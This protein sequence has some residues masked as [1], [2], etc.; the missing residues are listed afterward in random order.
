MKFPPP[1][2]AALA[3]LCFLF[4][5][6]AQGAKPPEEPPPRSVGR[7]IEVNVVRG[8]QCE[9]V[10]RGI[11]MPKNSV[12]FQV[13]KPPIHGTLGSPRRIDKDTV[14]Y[15]YK[16]NGLA[17]ADRDR[18]DFKIKTG[19]D[20]AWGRVAAKIWI[21]EP[22][23]RFIAEPEALDFGPVPIGESK[24]LDLRIRN[25]GGGLLKGSAEISPP[26]SIRGDSD[27]EL[28]EGRQIDLKVVFSPKSPDAQ[29]G[30]MNFKISSGARTAVTLRGMGEYRFEIPERVAFPA[31]AGA[32]PITVPVR[33]RSA[34]PLTLHITAEPPLRPTVRL[35]LPPGGSRSFSLELEKG[36]YSGKLGHVVVSDGLADQ[37]VRVELPPSPALLEWEQGPVMDLGKIPFRHTSELEAGLKNIGAT[38]TAVTLSDGFGGLSL[39]PSQARSF[40]LRSGETALVKLVWKLPEQPGV[41]EAKLTAQEGGVSHELG[42]KILVESPV[43]QPPFVTSVQN[44]TKPTPS[45]TP[46]DSRKILSDSER[47]EL[48]RRMPQDVSY[49]LELGSGSATAVVN[50]KYSG[51]QPVLFVLERQVTERGATGFEKVFEKR[52]EVPEQLPAIPLIQKWVP[53]DSSIAGIALGEDGR[54]QGRVP[55][56]TAGFHQLRIAAKSPPEGKRTDYVDFTV[57]VGRL[58]WPGWVR[59]A[60]A[61]LG[62]LSL[63]YLLRRKIAGWFGSPV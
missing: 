18:G 31:R 4:C 5:G 59:L 26:W 11:A 47:A 46:R 43:E 13:L 23:S 49:R 39:A 57:H 10:L 37:K 25:D 6:V 48:Q 8:G 36:Y 27:F 50:W 44:S 30:P 56:L 41:V 34:V 7:D 42:F 60:L 15:T 21:H 55:G 14:V 52:L 3:A 38:P 29:T 61:V 20:H 24:A 53:V 33:N 51:S 16:H 28:A 2:F 58:P 22:P 40:E 45:P 17:G 35:D 19:R 32:G 63:V 1:T 62:V 54:W 9:L 12:E